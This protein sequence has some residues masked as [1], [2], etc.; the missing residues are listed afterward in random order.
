V[1]PRPVGF[2]QV[3][4]QVQRQ[5]QARRPLG[6][7]HTVVGVPREP[8]DLYG[9][10][11]GARI[12]FLAEIAVLLVVQSVRV[13]PLPHVVHL[14]PNVAAATAR[15]SRTGATSCTRKTRAPRS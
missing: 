2:T 8:G 13:V 12:A 7:G 15:A 3:A 11:L 5:R 10:R 6:L 1:P 4:E 14:R 9:Y